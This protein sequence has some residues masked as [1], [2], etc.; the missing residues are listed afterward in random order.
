MVELLVIDLHFSILLFK[1]HHT[2]RCGVP[3]D[4]LC[5]L[6]LIF[7]FPISHSIYLIIRAVVKNV[8]KFMKKTYIFS[9][10]NNNNGLCH[11]LSIRFTK[12]QVFVRF[13]YYLYL[14]F[15]FL[16]HLN[17]ISHLASRM[18]LFDIFP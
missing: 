1:I 12:I 14:R 17:A 4:F 8:G 16:G 6:S 11:L 10:D 3:A 5:V 18:T 2:K 15:V 9:I 13:W 7:E